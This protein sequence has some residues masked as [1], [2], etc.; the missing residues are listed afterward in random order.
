VP[1]DRFREFMAAYAAAI[2]LPPLTPPAPSIS[3]IES[4]NLAH[5]GLLMTAALLSFC[6]MAVAIRALSGT[7]SIMEILAIRGAG[8]P[9]LE[10]A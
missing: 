2:G 3:R 10:A 1:L 7:L 4:P 5:A 8:G 9:D 6:A